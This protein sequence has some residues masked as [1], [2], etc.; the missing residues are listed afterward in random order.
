SLIREAVL[1]AAGVPEHRWRDATQYRPSYNCSPGAWIPVIK[2]GPDGARELQ[3]MKWGLVPSFTRLG[4]G[5]RPD[6]FRMFNARSESLMQKS[7]FSRLLPRKRCIVLLDGFYEWFAHGGGGGAASRKQPYHITTADAPEKPAMYLAGLYDVYRDSNGEQGHTFTIITTD[8]SEPLAWLHDRMPVILTTDEEISAWL[9]EKAPKDKA[10]LETL[11]CYETDETDADLMR[12]DEGLIAAAA[13]A[14][15]APTNL[16]Y[17][18]ESPHSQGTAAGGAAGANA[19]TAEAGPGGG[20]G[21]P[22]KPSAPSSVGV[23]RRRP[24]LAASET[25]E[26]EAGAVSPM[27]LVDKDGGDKAEEGSGG[28]ES[29]D[30]DRC[31]WGE[32]QSCQEVGRNGAR[33]ERGDSETNTS[34]RLEVVKQQCKV[35]VEEVCRP[36]GGPLLRWHPVTPEMSKPG[37][38]KPDCCK[39]VRTK[40][41][42]IASFFKPAAAPRAMN[43][44]ATAAPRATPFVKK[45]A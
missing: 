4:P 36:Y 3:T 20:G 1:T 42:S 31:F 33:G 28:G 37:Y 16:E 29:R 30:E 10:G 22:H 44:A 41:G 9:G 12:R 32:A 2:L 27:M 23:K 11:G 8:S 38:D 18:S 15:V 19:G 5:E 39:D 7:V 45:E 43:T 14:G 35:L 26:A 40:K 34:L 17:L 21:A 24:S 6:H 13:A 25:K